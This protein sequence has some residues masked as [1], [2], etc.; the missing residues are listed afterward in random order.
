MQKKKLIIP[1]LVNKKIPEVKLGK[2]WHINKVPRVRNSADKWK[3]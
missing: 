1:I 3:L 2:P